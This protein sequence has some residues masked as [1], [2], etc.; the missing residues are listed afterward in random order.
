MKDPN[1]MLKQLLEAGV[2][3]GHRTNRWNPKM[4]RYIF[5]EKNGIYIIDLEKTVE[6]IAKACEFLNEVVSRGEYVLFV[7]TKRQAQSIIRE[8]AKRCSMFYVVERW[9][10]GTLTNFKTIKQSIK[11]L[12]ELETLKNSATFEALSKKERAQISKELDKLMKNLEGIRRMTYLPSALFLIDSKKEEIAV[13]EANKLS[14]PVVALIDTNADPD[15]VNYPIPGND[16]AIRSVELIT[17]IIA[18]SIFEGRQRFIAST[19]ASTEEISEEQLMM[20]KIDEEK[21]ELIAGEGKIKEG[22]SKEERIKKK[23][24]KTKGTDQGKKA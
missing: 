23:P 24:R 21:I 1:I 10:G 16:D 14:I 3:F 2:H 11:R 18:D 5:G 19:P 20:D 8:E 13:K 22:E 6:R 7:G 15:K 9:L 17:K 4:G 12:D